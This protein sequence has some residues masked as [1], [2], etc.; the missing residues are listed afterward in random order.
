MT[1]SPVRALQRVTL[2]V[3][4]G[5]RVVAAAIALAMMF[6]IV[7]DVVMR[8]AFDR[9][10]DWALPLNALAVLAVTFLAIPDLFARDEHITVDMAVEKMP[11]A[12]QRAAD[13]VVR[14]ATLLFGVVLAWLGFDYAWVTWTGGLTTSGL[15]T[16]PQW[17]I[18]MP[19]PLAGVM[20][21]LTAVLPRA[22]AKSPEPTPADAPERARTDATE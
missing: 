1:S 3:T 13:V 8:Y 22:P 15:F 4:G 19:I 20:L 9:P 5:F 2:V 21:A 18:V 7:Y 17:V 12:G 10:T 16:M 14:V 11:Q 6:S